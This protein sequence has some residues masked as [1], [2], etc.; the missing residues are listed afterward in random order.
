MRPAPAG[1]VPEEASLVVP[2][3]GAAW[4]QMRTNGKRQT[5]QLDTKAC[6]GKAGL[7]HG[8]KKRDRCQDD[9]PTRNQQEKSN[10]SHEKYEYYNNAAST[11]AA[12]IVV[13][14]DSVRLSPTIS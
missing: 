6:E 5:K 14:V 12:F 11:R 4:N 10:Q 7:R 3:L 8:L 9:D 1:L 13:V 2:M